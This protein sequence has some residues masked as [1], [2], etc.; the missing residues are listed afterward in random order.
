[1]SW[2]ANT[3][4]SGV[5][6][7]VGITRKDDASTIGCLRRIG[8]SDDRRMKNLRYFLTL[9]ANRSRRSARLIDKAD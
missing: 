7:E 1:V 8:F 4:K 5:D 3:D 9:D 2:A 6:G